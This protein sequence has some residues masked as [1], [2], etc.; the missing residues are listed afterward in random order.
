MRQFWFLYSHLCYCIFTADILLEVNYF[1]RVLSCVFTMAIGAGCFQVLLDTAQFVW[2][3]FTL[4][5]CSFLT[6]LFAYSLS[7]YKNV[8]LLARERIPWLRESVYCLELSSQHPLWVTHTA[9]NSR[10]RG[11]DTIFWS[12][13]L[14]ALSIPQTRPQTYMHIYINKGLTE[15][16]EVV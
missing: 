6:E 10:S 1:S 8:C 9:S 3:M 12:L 11:S 7:C 13:H 16:I 15:I 4:N 14:C 2:E 5:L